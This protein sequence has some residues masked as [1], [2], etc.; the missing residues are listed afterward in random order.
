MSELWKN[1]ARM[2][3]VGNRHPVL[4]ARPETEK[5]MW[6]SKSFDGTIKSKWTLRNCGGRDGIIF[7]WL[8]T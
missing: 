8:T 6:Y 1:V 5:I 7:I 4:V 2:E 3:D